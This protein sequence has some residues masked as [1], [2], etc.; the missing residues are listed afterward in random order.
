MQTRI[1]CAPNTRNITTL[2]LWLF[3]LYASTANADIV[4]SSDQGFSLH[5]EFTTSLAPKQTYEEF[6]QIGRWWNRDHTW[7][8]DASGLYIEP[9]SGGCFCEKSGLKTALHMTISFVEPGKEMRMIGG[10]GPL[11]GMALNGVM[12][13][14]FEPHGHNGTK[15]IH[16]YTVTGY[17][18][19]GLQKLGEIVDAVQ[20]LQMQGLQA[21]LDKIQAE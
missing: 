8:G 3:L 17:S 2:I 19:N 15:V 7:F 12:K 5:I 16:E 18:A 4:S 6:L 9:I 10:L 13:F 20:S 21:R 11:Q 1:D 14:K